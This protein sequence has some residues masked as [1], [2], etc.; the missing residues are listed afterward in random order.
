MRSQQA[1][2]ACHLFLYK[3][4]Y[5]ETGMPICLALFITAFTTKAEL[6][7]CGRDQMAHEA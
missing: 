3:K 2:A 5:G 6:S 7:I 1:R 4:L